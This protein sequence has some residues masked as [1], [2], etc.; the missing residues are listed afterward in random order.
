MTCPHCNE[1][2]SPTDYDCAACGKPVARTREEL[3]RIDVRTSK[4]I[5]WALVGMGLAGYLFVIINS[6]TDWFSA[7]D[8]VAPT[9]VLLA[10]LG[11]L[12]WAK[13]KG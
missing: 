3:N 5:A 8:F 12:L 2:I 6:Q 4:G 10:G 1:A 9:A 11:G 7:L 13:R